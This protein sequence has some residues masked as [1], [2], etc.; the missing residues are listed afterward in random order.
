MQPRRRLHTLEA[1][2]PTTPARGRADARLGRLRDQLA[3]TALPT[4]ALGGMEVDDIDAAQVSSAQKLAAIPLLMG[5]RGQA[6]KPIPSGV[7]QS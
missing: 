6:S 2:L 7:W 4:Y 5:R 3:A 1:R